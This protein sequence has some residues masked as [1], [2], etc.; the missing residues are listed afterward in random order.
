M[1]FEIK[2]SGF[3]VGGSLNVTPVSM[4]TCVISTKVDGQHQK[5]IH[6]RNKK[7]KGSKVRGADSPYCLSCPLSC[8]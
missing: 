8:Q 4:A 7:E 1:S 6:I 2:M 5:L 3:G